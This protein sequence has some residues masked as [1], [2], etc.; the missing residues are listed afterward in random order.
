M[1]R[2]QINFH[3]GCQITTWRVTSSIWQ[4]VDLDFRPAV[5][6]HESFLGAEFRSSLDNRKPARVLD[7]R[8]I[9]LVWKGAPGNQ[10]RAG[11]K[12]GLDRRGDAEQS[13]QEKARLMHGKRLS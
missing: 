10:C 12:R 4:A 1:H 5:R 9:L 11:W 8:P 13:Y 2:R 7:T 3:F 6:G